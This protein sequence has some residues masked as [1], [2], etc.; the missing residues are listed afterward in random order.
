MTVRT[1]LDTG[2]LIAAYQGDHASHEVALKII[3]ESAE[4]EFVS[5]D[6]VKLELLPKALF[7]RRAD[8]FEFYNTFLSNVDVRVVDSNSISVGAFELSSKYGLAACDALH[9]HTAMNSSVTEFITTEKQGKAFFRIP[10]NI[11]TTTSIH[12]NIKPKNKGFLHCFLACFINVNKR[13]KFNP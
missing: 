1:Y 10:A 9:I 6:L 4:R 2:V 11:L 13:Q 5:S 8:E 3:M 12:V 7:Y